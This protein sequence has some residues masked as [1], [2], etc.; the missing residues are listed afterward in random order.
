M[1]TSRSGCYF[2][3]QG[4]KRIISDYA[5]VHSVEG[6][7]INAGSDDP[8]KPLRLKSGGHGQA[9]FKILKKAHVGYTIVK[10]YSNGVRIGNVEYHYRKAMRV[11]NKQTWV[12][13]SW[14]KY[15]ILRA[16]EHVA[17][18]KCNK[19]KKDGEH[20]IWNVERSKSSC[21]KTQWS[22]TNNSTYFRTTK[23]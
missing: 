3:T 12:P 17:S 6:T 8:Q 13:K 18:L 11:Y 10:T 7:Y 2:N 23:K 14:T 9:M 22:T 15:D 4:S 5:L 16:G 1:G 20:M 19:H 21:Y